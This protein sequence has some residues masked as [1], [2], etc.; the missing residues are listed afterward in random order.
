MENKLKKVCFLIKDSEQ[1]TKGKGLS[2][3]ALHLSPYKPIKKSFLLQYLPH[4][5][6]DKLHCSSWTYPVKSI[7]KSG[8]LANQYSEFILF[9]SF[10]DELCSILCR[11]R[12]HCSFFGV[13]V[14]FRCFHSGISS[15]IGCNSSRMN[16]SYPYRCFF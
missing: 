6:H 12:L 3:F 13:G 5:L 15:D 1:K 8:I 7:Q 16:N 11:H 14:H 9:D 2:P 4:L 10:N